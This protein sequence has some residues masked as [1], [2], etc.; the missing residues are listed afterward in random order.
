[1]SM[2]ESGK[3]DALPAVYDNEENKALGH[4]SNTI[5]EMPFSV[6][7][8]PNVAEISSIEQLFGKTVA[9]TQG[10]SFSNILRNNYPQIT[11]RE[12]PLLKDVIEE[13][14]QGKSLCRY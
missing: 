2:Y 9:I 14:R 10:W 7:T 8:A 11:L 5:M 6:I 1:M 12:V 4:L 13:V 3:L